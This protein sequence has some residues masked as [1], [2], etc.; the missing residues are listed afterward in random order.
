MANLTDIQ[1][2]DSE[3]LE[4]VVEAGYEDAVEIATISEAQLSQETGITLFKAKELIEEA[5][6]L[7]EPDP[8]STAAE[9]EEPT[10]LTEIDVITEV[11]GWELELETPDRLIWRTPSDYSLHLTGERLNLWGELPP[12]PGEEPVKENALKVRRTLKEEF[13]DPTE[14]VGY[15]IGWMESHP[16]EFDKDLTEFPGISHRTAEYLLFVHGVQN[17]QALF[18]LY[19]EGELE[20]IVGSH[21]HEELRDALDE[22]FGL[23]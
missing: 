11:E 14:A 5:K 19:K 6:Q 1:G 16:I 23:Q 21:F 2:V 9:I 12:K 7:A 20:E 15:A 22:Q 3:I 18:E 13:D 8:F 4:S 10:D 17:H